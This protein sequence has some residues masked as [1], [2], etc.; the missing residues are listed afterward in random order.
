M[1]I[2]EELASMDI[3]LPQ[4]TVPALLAAIST[5]VQ[6]RHKSLH[7][8]LCAMRQERHQRWK[9][10]LPTL[11]KERPRVIHHWL[12][13]AG[14]LAWGTTPILDTAGQ[15]CLTLEAVDAAVRGYRV[16]TVLR[17]HASVDEAAS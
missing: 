6:Q 8:E 10:T 5:E 16:D 1:Q 7:C 17:H 3:V 2:L 11:W 9:A 15:Q 4:T 13:A 12:H 14:S